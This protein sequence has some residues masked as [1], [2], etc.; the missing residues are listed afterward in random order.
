MYKLFKFLIKKN[1]PKINNYLK[2]F[3]IKNSRKLKKPYYWRNILKELFD[4]KFTFK[5]IVQSIETWFATTFVCPRG[6]GLEELPKSFPE[7]NFI[8]KS[9]ITYD[10]INSELGTIDNA[11]EY[12]IATILEIGKQ[13]GKEVE[14]KN[15]V[16]KGI[17][18]EEDMNKYIMG[19]K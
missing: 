8:D 2:N 10:Y 16:S 18:K 7:L 19:V 6:I 13:I 1:N 12:Y 11:N 9:K 4:K 5:E 15:L 14:R 3:F 17:I